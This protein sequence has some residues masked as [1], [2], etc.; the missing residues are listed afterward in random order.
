M[1]NRIYLD[2]AATTPVLP[3]VLEEMLPFFTD[4]F[5]NPHTGSHYLRIFIERYI[6][7]AA[8]IIKVGTKNVTDRSSLLHVFHFFLSFAHRYL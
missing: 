6:T 3:E 8:E 5:G 7:V 2:Y 4:Q 1:K